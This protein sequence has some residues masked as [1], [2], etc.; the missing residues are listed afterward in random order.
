MTLPQL[1]LASESPRR[2]QLLQ[3]IGLAFEVLLPGTTEEAHPP[4]ES[5]A[6]AVVLANATAKAQSILDRMSRRDDV[7]LGADTL[8]LLDEVAIGKPKDRPDAER[9]LRKLSGRT[10]TVITGIA[11]VSPKFGRRTTAV[12]SGV[13]FRTLSEREISDYAS[14][15]EPYDKAGA[16]AVQGMGALFIDRIDGS[17]TNVMGLPIEAVMTELAALTHIPLHEWFR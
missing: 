13:T 8:V 3:A 9:I 4:N 5:E 2:K 14:T 17:Y 15:R 11:L 12:R 6:Q 7:A 1:Y 10:Q 16:Y